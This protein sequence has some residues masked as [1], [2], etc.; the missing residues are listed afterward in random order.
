MVAP[1]KH[2]PTLQLAEEPFTRHETYFFE[3]GNV[4]FLVNN[5]LYCV[6]RYFARDSDAFSAAFRRLDTRGHEE[7]D[8]IISLDDVER[9]DFEAFLSILYPSQFDENKHSYEQWKAVLHLSTLWGFASVRRL[10]LASLKPPTPFD[11]LLLG[12]AYSVDHYIVP[13][14]SL[15]C[16]RP[17]PLTLGEVRQMSAED[18][19]LITSVRES[20]RGPMLNF[21]LSEISNL[22]QLMQSRLHGESVATGEAKVEKEAE[23][24]TAEQEGAHRAAIASNNALSATPET[25]TCV[26]GRSGRAGPR[27]SSPS[28]SS[29]TFTPGTHP[30][31]AGPWTKRH[32]EQSATSEPEHESP[33]NPTPS[34]VPGPASSTPPVFPISCV[35]HGPDEI[36]SA[37]SDAE[38]TISKTSGRPEASDADTLDNATVSISETSSDQVAGSYPAPV[39]GILTGLPKTVAP[40]LEA[41][42]S[43]ET[44]SHLQ[45]ASEETEFTATRIPPPVADQQVRLPTPSNQ[46]GAPQNLVSIAEVAEALSPQPVG[47][48]VAPISKGVIVDSVGG[49]KP[50]TDVP[51]KPEG[52]FVAS[53]TSARSYSRPAIPAVDKAAPPA[54]PE[55]HG[56]QGSAKR[57][58]KAQKRR[59][60]QKLLRKTETTMCNCSICQR[61]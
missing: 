22:V 19:V 59:M 49:K 23:E 17:E 5:L 52:F 16:E 43:Q 33:I 20:I 56:E 48:E 58:S 24:Q 6:H 1:K 12:R 18:V 26:L 41:Q 3:D 60:K 31:S 38:E 21:E 47:P 15:L 50:A 7:L 42:L 40:D 54:I 36:N 28:V 35:T 30:C 61:Q 9:V 37:E 4:T 46:L 13:A 29:R 44:T 2:H 57:L 10:A 32:A 53:V 14:L 8:V 39:Q 27:T 34:I 55:T 45:P 25:R 51:P 11:Q